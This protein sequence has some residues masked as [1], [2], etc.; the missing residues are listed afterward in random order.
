[1]PIGTIIG[2]FIGTFI[3][4]LTIYL[5]HTPQKKFGMSEQIV[6]ERQKIALIGFAMIIISIAALIGTF[7]EMA[8]S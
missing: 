2:F 7:I 6:L 3:I 5:N 4:G 1:M 8:V